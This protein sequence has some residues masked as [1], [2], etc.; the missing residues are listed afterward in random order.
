M[1]PPLLRRLLLFVAARAA[2]TALSPKTRR[3]LPA[4]LVLADTRIRRALQKGEDGSAIEALLL[5]SIG[6]VTAAPASSVDLAG[7]VSLFD[8]TRISGKR[9]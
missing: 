6:Q 4:I 3:C 7:L 9:P 2:L 1:L 8:P 5:S